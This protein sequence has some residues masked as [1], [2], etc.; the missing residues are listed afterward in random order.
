MYASAADL[1]EQLD[2]TELAS[3]ATPRRFGAAVDAD[4][5]V[6]TIEE[7]DRSAWTADD[8]EAADAALARINEILGEQSLAMDGYL[9]GL[10]DLPLTD[11]TIAANPLK[12]TCVRMA[13]YILTTFSA[14]SA[15]VRQRY[16]DA[17]H[18][19]GQV[20]RGLVRLRQ[21]DA[22]TGASVAGSGF[23]AVSGM[24]SS[25]YNLGAY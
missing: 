15:D 1:L 18:W 16:E 17:L 3:I 23:V 5:L 6:A 20:S 4:L 7:A 19:L 2:A 24:P 12:S 25:G 8:I 13:H 21:P 11:E 9:G 22:V 14:P 10:Y